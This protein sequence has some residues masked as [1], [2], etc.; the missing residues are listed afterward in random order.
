[1]RFGTPFSAGFGAPDNMVEYVRSELAADQTSVLVRFKPR[2]SYGD[3][4]FAVH[5]NSARLVNIY[6]PDGEETAVRCAL[7][8]GAASSAV[9]V[10]RLGFPG[11][12]EYECRRV[13]RTYESTE[14]RRVTLEFVFA[15]QIIGA[16]GDE[17]YTSDW[18]LAGLRYA[19]TMAVV[20]GQPTRGRLDF[21]L[22]VAE[23]AVTVTLSLH[24]RAVASGAA[25]ISASP[26]VV[27]LAEEQASGVAGHVTVSPAVA[28]VSGAALY[29]R[30]PA[31]AKIRRGASTPPAEVVAVACFRGQE[32]VRWTEP[33]ELAAGTYYYRLTAVSDTGEDGAES[34]VVSVTLSGAPRP[35]T[36]LAYLEGGAADTVLQ[37]LSSPTEGAAYRAYLQPPGAAP[38]N[39]DDAPCATASSHP[40]WLAGHAYVLGEMVAPSVWNGR[41]YEC[42]CAGTTGPS[43]PAWPLTPGA[44]VADGSVEWTCRAYQMA[45]PAV[46]GCPGV[47]RVLLRAVKDGVEE[48]NLDSLELEYDAGGDYVPPRPNVPG[49]DTRRLSVADGLTLTVRGVYS[50]QGQRGGATELRMFTRPLGGAYDYAE[51]VATAALSAVGPNGLQTATLI[52]AFSAA[53]W[54]YVRLLA[55]TAAGTLSD[56]AGAPEALVYVSTAA[57]PAPVEFSAWASRG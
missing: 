11:E 9:L 20:P 43:A 16:V 36:G 32:G 14:N 42:T 57:A 24:G 17:G 4:I 15:P 56:P 19:R 51:P 10:L 26:F 52:H 39:L 38:L 49:L 28:S 2:T 45:L 25:P 18:D 53:G 7:P 13:A 50:S 33:S 41:R 5:L 12:P 21:D 30:W 40:L 46:T 44:T 48:R 35:P 1:M 34:D 27:Q 22:A 54:R 23:G 6:A 3:A 31:A 37:F 8:W 55:A 47:A 29:A